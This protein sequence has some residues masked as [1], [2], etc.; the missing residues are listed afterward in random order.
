MGRLGPSSRLAGGVLLAALL[1]VAVALIVGAGCGGSKNEPSPASS[2]AS[3]SPAGTAGQSA[4]SSPPSAQAPSPAGPADL[5]AQVFA[6]RCV[7]CHGPDG[8]GDGPGAKGLKPQPRNFH[9]AAYMS[10]RTDAELLTTIHL[11]RGPMPRWQGVL[12][13]SEMVAVL[14]HIRE[15]GKK[16]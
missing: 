16:P 14:K 4:P 13:E 9:D 3:S 6:K 12:S 5:G 8:H 15:L 1:G 2:N 10:T 11:G 7:L